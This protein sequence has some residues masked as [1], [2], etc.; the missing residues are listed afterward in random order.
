MHYENIIVET[1]GRVGLVTLNRPKA[2][3]VLSDALI[4][5]PGHTIE[6]FDRNDEIRCMVVTGSEKAFAAGADI[7]RNNHGKTD[8]GIHKEATCKSSNPN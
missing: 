3:N 7:A 1:R 6:Q 8:S 4:D 5:E 2:L